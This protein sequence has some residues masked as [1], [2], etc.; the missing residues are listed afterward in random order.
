MRRS[1][2]QL[3]PARRQWIT[4]ESR[5]AGRMG[6]PHLPPS[7]HIQGDELSDTLLT[8]ALDAHAVGAHDKYLAWLNDNFE[9]LSNA[10]ADSAAP[11]GGAWLRQQYTIET[12]LRP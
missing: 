11:D 5:L 6:V 1:Y 3:S 10:C 8:K 2:A 4:D 7:V 9:R 12:G